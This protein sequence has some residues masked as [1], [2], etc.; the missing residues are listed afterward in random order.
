VLS[1]E[2]GF[3]HYC[4][5]GDGGLQH[6]EELL[7]WFHPHTKITTRGSSSSSSSGS[8]SSRQLYQWHPGS[9]TAAAVAISKPHHNRQGRPPNLR[10][11]KTTIQCHKTLS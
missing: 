7:P 3:K 11:G 4:F 8:S 6:M 2:S 1:V 5:A 9:S 10:I